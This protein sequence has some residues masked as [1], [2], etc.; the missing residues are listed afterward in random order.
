M[1]QLHSKSSTIS[2]A[3]TL[4]RART[5]PPFQGTQTTQ[6]RRK[7]IPIPQCR[8][9]EAL[10]PRNYF[11]DSHLKRVREE[12]DGLRGIPSFLAPA[13]LPVIRGYQV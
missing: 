3:G 11:L 6:S 13:E 5:P 4:A 7:F 9:G 10:K 8:I 12:D 2:P 1:K